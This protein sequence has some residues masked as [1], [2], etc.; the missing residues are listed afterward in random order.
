M[1]FELKEDECTAHQVLLFESRLCPSEERSEGGELGER[2][3]EILEVGCLEEATPNLRDI[4]S[5]RLFL[6]SSL[7]SSDLDGELRELSVEGRNGADG[8]FE[9]DA[10]ASKRGVD[11]GGECFL[12]SPERS[13]FVLRV[14][15]LGEEASDLSENIASGSEESRVE[16]IEDSKNFRIHSVFLKVIKYHKSDS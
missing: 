5:G 16:L 12:G 1:R 3:R 7:D 4:E 2:G 10:S 9:G 8:V 6:E 11:V 13:E 15:F 14:V